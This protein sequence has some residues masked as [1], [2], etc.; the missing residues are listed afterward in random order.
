MGKE[1]TITSQLHNSEVQT[2]AYVIHICQI[3]EPMKPDNIQGRG[4]CCCASH[5]PSKPSLNNGNPVGNRYRAGTQ[6]R[7]AALRRGQGDT[8]ATAALLNP[9]LSITI[10]A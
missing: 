2:N 7:I 8:A 9:E 1:Q 5:C 10:F 6:L 3:C 4:S